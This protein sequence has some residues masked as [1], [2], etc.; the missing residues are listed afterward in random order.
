MSGAGQKSKRTTPNGE[1]FPL[2]D[3]KAVIVAKTAPRVSV[4]V[5][6]RMLVFTGYIRD[7]FNVVSNRPQ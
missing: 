3:S 5:V 7:R 4:I 6:S 2:D 1:R